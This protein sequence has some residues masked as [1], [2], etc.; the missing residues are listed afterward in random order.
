MS[1][2]SDGMSSFPGSLIRAANSPKAVEDLPVAPYAPLMKHIILGMALVLFASCGSS[3][4]GGKNPDGQQQPDCKSMKS[5]SIHCPL[6]DPSVLTF[7]TKSGNLRVLSAAVTGLDIQIL[8]PAPAVGLDLERQF[9]AAAG[10]Q[11]VVGQLGFSI[12]GNVST[13]E[14]MWTGYLTV[15]YTSPA[16]GTIQSKMFNIFDYK[17]LEDVEFQKVTYSP[18]VQMTKAWLAAQPN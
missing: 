7:R 15:T 11:H 5:A 18:G 8:K 17:I 2:I 9:K 13:E 3:S 1:I 4:D 10:I 16:D 6:P 12:E 14:S